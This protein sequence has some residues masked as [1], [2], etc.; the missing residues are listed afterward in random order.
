MMNKRI[1]NTIILV[2]L[3]TTLAYYINNARI[4][5]NNFFNINKQIQSIILIN[6][7]FDLYLNK[8]FQ[9]NNFDHIQNKISTFQNTYEIIQKNQTLLKSNDIQITQKTKKLEISISKKLSII[10]KANS[11]RA[12]L[13]KSYVII[14]RIKKDGI[15]KKL[16]NLYTIVMTLDK[17]PSVDLKSTLKQVYSLM[18]IYTTKNDKFFLKHTKAILTYK[19][20]LD[21]ITKTLEK[22]SLE[23]ELTSFAEY[24]NQHSQEIIQMA[25]L[26]ILILFLLLILSLIFYILYDYK[27]STSKKLLKRFRKTIEDSENIIIITDE[28]IKIKYV[29]AAFTKV[30]GYTIKEVKGKSPK[31]FSSGKQHKEFYSNLHNTI[32]SGQKWQGEFINKTKDGK[33][34]YEQ[35]TITPSLD[36]DN[37]II[38]FVAIKLDTT[39]EKL[40]QEQ[41]VKKEK[42][43]LQQSKMASMGEMLQNI[44][45]QWRQPL[46]LISTA[47][48]G[49]LVKKELD[50]ETTKEED[51]KILNTIN[52]STQY[53][54]ETINAFSDYFRPSKE[55]INFNIYDVYNKTLNIVQTKF[56]DLNIKIIEDID[57]INITNLD[58]ELIQVLMNIL[59]NA[60]DALSTNQKKERI[61]FVTIKKIE[62]NISIK[63][64]DNA[65]G[66]PENL[67]DKI[68]EPYF[69]TKHKSQGTGIG[70]Y[71][72]QEIIHQHMNGNL[73]VINQEFEYEKK[74]YTGAEFNISFPIEENN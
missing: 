4:Q 1:L 59:N 67:L 8:S 19:D 6:K 72:C 61:I 11:Y 23:K 66:I 15:H 44:A 41:L 26:A 52:D 56:K 49:L 34:I 9:Y 45:H 39:K 18:N 17:N 14:Q 20:N 53:L 74:K 60:K 51:I 64:K 71:M 63:I 68:F 58:N 13:N 48:T 22:G 10:N 36:E 62:D 3:L 12:I 70:L 25:Y 55:K 43:L 38:E 73:K 24:Y 35:A 54:S 46:S 30:T 7:D 32:F 42:L 5:N 33:L 28:N 16:N 47:S 50:V 27:L 69:T 57:N 65:G 21:N 29:N 40:A 2:V 37:N 31:M